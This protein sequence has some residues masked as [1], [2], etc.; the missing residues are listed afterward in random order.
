MPRPMA[1]AARITCKVGLPQPVDT[2]PPNTGSLTEICSEA[3]GG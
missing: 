2:H 3:G 1:A